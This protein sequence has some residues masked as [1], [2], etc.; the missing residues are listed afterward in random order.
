MASKPLIVAA[1]A[2][3]LLVLTVWGDATMNRTYYVDVKD[4]DGWRTVAQGGD[5]QDDTRAYPL[6]SDNAIKIQNGTPLEMRLRVDNEY[7]WAFS[8]TFVASA[9]GLILAEGKIESPARSAGVAEFSVNAS[10][11]LSTQVF[12]EKPT[13]GSG[14]SQASF[15]LT[16]AGQYLYVYFPVEVVS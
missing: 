1:V 4:G 13:P 16:I 11:V 12:P 9:N 5:A 2:T 7:F 15:E 3:A 8:K 14:S 6:V 10:R